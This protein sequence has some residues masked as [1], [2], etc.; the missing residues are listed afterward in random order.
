MSKNRSKQSFPSNNKQVNPA[1]Q[2]IINNREQ[3]PDVNSLSQQDASEIEQIKQK[4]LSEVEIELE[5]YKL[6]R[7]EEIEEE[8]KR[9]LQEARRDFENDNRIA[10]EQLKQRAKEIDEKVASLSKQINEVS[11][12]RARIELQKQ[13]I[14]IQIRNELRVEIEKLVQ[15][16]NQKSSEI[17]NLKRQINEK[18]QYIAELTSDREY[19]SESFKK[20]SDGRNNEYL[21]EHKL[22]LR[23]QEFEMLNMAYIDLNRKFSDVNQLIIKYGDN[24]QELLAENAQFKN[25]IESLQDN[26][27]Q[28]PTLLELGLLR[29]KA[30][31]YVVLEKKNSDLEKRIIDLTR[32]IED[33]EIYKEEMENQRRFIKIIELQ[34]TELKAELDS[35]LSIYNQ[36]S[37]KVFSSLSLIDQEQGKD[38]YPDSGKTLKE[39]CIDFR[40]YLATRNNKTKLFYSEETIRTFIAGF[41]TSKIS[42]LEGLSGTGKSSLPRAFADFTGCNAITIPVQSSWKDRNDLLGF[43]NDFKKQ[44]K[45]TEFLKALYKAS[46]DYGN[47]YLIVLDEIN[48][49]RVEYYFADILSVLEKDDPNHWMLDLI[50]DNVPGEMPKYIK[51]GKLRITS[52]IWFVGTANKDDSTFT[53]TDKVY[54]RSVVIDFQ[55]KETAFVSQ[56][57]FPIKLSFYEFETILEKSLKYSDLR[58]EEAV[59]DEI[60]FLDDTITDLFEVTFGNRIRMQIDKFVPAYIACGGT[61][62]E[63]L[64]VVFSKKVL[65][66]LHGRYDEATKKALQD[67]EVLL[68][69]RYKDKK[70]FVH[71]KSAVKRMLA[72]IG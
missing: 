59:E 27:K 9:T 14:Q 37:D 57:V 40:R 71:S 13:E 12:E 11:A 58:T 2:N 6:K 31:D 65:R 28:Y 26:L 53:I 43:Y 39:I 7:Y 35:I 63:A 72:E 56:N 42:I 67:F 61:Y 3:K 29:A 60:E 15:E 48:L 22:Q 55:K 23:N 41:A 24:P 38:V 10:E 54:D 70:D 32:E 34:K 33:I 19:L 47:I 44:Y 36:R 30:E 5:S 4:R 49:S 68:S 8:K 51:Q 25:E 20:I 45:E 21:L 52:N 64:D 66:K 46:T 18:E 62:T 50:P 16:M 17:T 69:D 1:K